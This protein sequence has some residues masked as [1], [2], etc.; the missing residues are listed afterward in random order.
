MILLFELDDGELILV[1]FS[2]DLLVDFLFQYLNLMFRSLE[3]RQDF[4]EISD[5]LS[6]MKNVAAFV[7]FIDL[8]LLD[9][10]LDTESHTG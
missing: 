3:L 7:T 9:M 4:P 5:F 8:L 2:R 1:G 6:V 10:F